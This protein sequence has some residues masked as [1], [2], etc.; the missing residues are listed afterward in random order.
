MA[1]P[2]TIGILSNVIG[3]AAKRFPYDADGHLLRDFFIEVV[4]LCKRGGL[5]GRTLAHGW[6]ST[7]PPGFMSEVDRLSKVAVP[8]M[9]NPVGSVAKLWCKT[10]VTLL[11]VVCV[12]FMVG[13]SL[14]LHS[15]AQWL[16]LG[17][18]EVA[19]LLGRSCCG[20]LAFLSFRE[21]CNEL[22]PVELMDGIERLAEAAFSDAVAA[23]AMKT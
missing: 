23:S 19:R 9:N 21:T 22:V 2:P 18:P 17:Y 6:H 16:R 13:A 14:R 20:C 15:E 4:T 8:G 5:G 7:P 1:S 10:V 11:D 12:T 3:F